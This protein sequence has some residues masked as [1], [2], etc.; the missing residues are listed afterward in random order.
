MISQHACVVYRRMKEYRQSDSRCGCR[1]R[2]L[3]IDGVLFS[4]KLAAFILLCRTLRQAPYSIDRIAAAAVASS[5]A[6]AASAAAATDDASDHLVAAAQHATADVRT[7]LPTV[8]DYRGWR[9]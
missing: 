6:S 9:K 3:V 2:K 8:R 7:C 4:C 5:D 1:R